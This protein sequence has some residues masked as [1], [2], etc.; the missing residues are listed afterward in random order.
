[1]TADR[2]LPH[3]R[4]AAIARGCRFLTEASMKGSVPIDRFI[5]DNV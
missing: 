3:L 1:M 2:L 5:I 4:L